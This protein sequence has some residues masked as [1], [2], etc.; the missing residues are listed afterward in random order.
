M[1]NSNSISFTIWL[2]PFSW[3][4]AKW[5]SHEEQLL[6]ALHFLPVF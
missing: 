1:V 5:F 6:H 4:Q 3:T 2:L